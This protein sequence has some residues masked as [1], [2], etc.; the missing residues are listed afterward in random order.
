MIEHDPFVS[1]IIYLAAAVITV[2]LF[3]KLGLG[4]ILGYLIA[5][6]LIGPQGLELIQNTADTLHFAEIGV[7][8]LLFVIGLELNPEKL[9]RMRAQ[10]MVLGPLQVGVTTI[11]L[12]I[13]SVLLLKQPFTVALVIGLALAL[14]STAFALQLMSDEGVL[15]SRPGRTGFALLMFQDIAVIPILLLL[16]ALAELTPETR[17]EHNWWVSTLAV[18]SVLALG[19]LLINHALKFIASYGS[20]E[21]MT[22]MALLIVLGT[23][24]LMY[25]AGA[26]M[27]M[28]AFIAGILLANS[29]FRHQLETD[30]EPFKGLLLGL[31]FIAIGMNLQLSLL[32]THPFFILLSAI[33]LMLIKGIVIFFLVRSRCTDV[34]Q[35]AKVALML[36]Q[37]GEFAF[38]IMT[39]A[40]SYRVIDNEVANTVSLIVGISMMLTSPFVSVVD[41]F[42]KPETTM[43]KPFDNERIVDK[44]EVIIAG[45][46]RFGQLT[47]RILSAN[48]ISFTALDR[49]AEHIE[50]VKQFGHQV[51]FGDAT[52]M[53]LLKTAGIDEASIILI[54]TDEYENNIKMV[55]EVRS[56]YPDKKIIARARN[57]SNTFDLISA[58]AD[59]VIRETFGSGLEAAMETLMAIG[60]TEGQA[61]QKT[62]IFRQHDEKLVQAALQEGMD[63]QALIKLSH[64]GRAELEQLFA[65]DRSN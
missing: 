34:K 8:L 59:H 4:A 58:G 49:D 57:R 27:G 55:R 44:P 1:I 43:D 40:V 10:I 54:A 26:T 42:F 22:A 38:V 41:R 47:G 45:F 48:H 51:F 35:S 53:D 33:T 9:W 29:S 61:L 28:G 17:N 15:A 24:Q 6:V 16:V 62:D 19:K 18:V 20:R 63:N 36:S 39:Q 30:I 46:G 13:V 64:N 2:P 31:F 23:A 65:R 5:G 60:F 3:K 32:L 21:I 12:L 14:S 25:A 56:H 50:F 11:V 52:R 37:G 7:V